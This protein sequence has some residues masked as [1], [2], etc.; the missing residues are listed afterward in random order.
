MHGLVVEAA[1]VEVQ[2]V[3]AGIIQDFYHR[4]NFDISKKNEGI[5]KLLII[6]MT[7]LLDADWLRGVQLFH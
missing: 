6:C 1:V 2:A 3:L 5:L 4:L 7:K